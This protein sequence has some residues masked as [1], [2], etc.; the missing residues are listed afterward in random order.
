MKEIIEGIKELATKELI[1]ANKKFPMFQSTH[2]GY[3]VL[4]EEVEEVKEQLRYVEGELIYT[5]DDVKRNKNINA[6]NHVKDLREY[7]INMAAE[8]IQVI[9]M[10]DKF[11]DSELV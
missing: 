2:E 5:W 8:C 6:V 7:A 10:T 9:A 11:I 3:A 4:L 1:S